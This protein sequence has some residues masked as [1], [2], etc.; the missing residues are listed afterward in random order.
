V[1]K[2]QY[3][4]FVTYFMAPLVIIIVATVLTNLPPPVPV[5]DALII[6]DAILG[7]ITNPTM[8]QTGTTILET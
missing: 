1:L 7:T 3:W 4:I 6:Q 8:P 2:I 5:P